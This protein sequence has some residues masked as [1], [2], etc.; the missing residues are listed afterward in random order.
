MVGTAQARLCPPYGPAADHA[1][2]RHEK[3]VPR[4]AVCRCR[5]SICHLSKNTRQTTR[6]QSFSREFE[7]RRNNP[8]ET[9]DVSSEYAV[10]MV[11][12]P[13]KSAFWQAAGPAGEVASVLDA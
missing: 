8:K 3:A 11:G 13:A 1:D 5:Q 10:Y 12:P 4:F 6:Y 7:G 9:H 2:T